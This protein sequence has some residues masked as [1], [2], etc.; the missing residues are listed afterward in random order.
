MIFAQHPLLQK[1][2]R[3]QLLLALL[4]LLLFSVG[5]SR[6]MPLR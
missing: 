3:S 2:V 5:N 4:L 1:S 6:A